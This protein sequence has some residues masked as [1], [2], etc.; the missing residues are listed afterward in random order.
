MRIYSDQQLREFVSSWQSLE[1]PFSTGSGNFF[2]RR[3]SHFQGKCPLEEVSGN[4]QENPL[5]VY[6]LDCPTSRLSSLVVEVSL[7]SPLV[8]WESSRLDSQL[9]KDTRH[10]DPRCLSV[11][12]EF[13]GCRN[14]WKSIRGDGKQ[15]QIKRQAVTYV[16]LVAQA[17]RSEYS[18]TWG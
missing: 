7:S 17:N 6:F 9:P 2:G 3:L 13:F 11:R 14:E 10:W 18:V 8:V 5:R 16:M 15:Q 1:L 12:N 4:F